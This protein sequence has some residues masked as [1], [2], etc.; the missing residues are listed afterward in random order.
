MIS[1]DAHRLLRAIRFSADKHRNQRR[2]DIDKTPY[3]NHPIEVAETLLSVGDPDD[4][5]V[6]IAAIL[7]DTIEDTET[8]PEEIET[9]FGRNVRSL[10]LEVTDDKNLPKKVRKQLQIENAPHKTPGAKKIKLA[11]KISNLRAII[12]FP[13]ADWSLERKIEYLN[14]SEKVVRGLRGADQKLEELYDQTLTEARK[15]L[16]VET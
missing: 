12:H 7:H 9:N 2:K 6:V 8:T 1:K 3:I 13:P 5:D 11:D 15:K 4:L 14:W 16:S 10:V